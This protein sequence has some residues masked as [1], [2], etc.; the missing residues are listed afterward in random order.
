MSP[1]L[2]IA[3][4][5]SPD[6]RQK[7][8]IEVL[9]K[10]KSITHLATE[11]QVSRKF[12]HQQ[13]NKAKKA[14]TECFETTTPDHEV[15]FYLPITKSW[16]TQLMLGLILICHSSY[17]GVVELLR[18]LFD[19][20]ISVGTIHNRLESAAESAAKINE[21][22]DLSR[23]KV[24]LHDEI[25]QGSQPVLT[26]VDA[27]SLYCYLLA[28]VE[29]RDQETWSWHLL[30]PMEQ[31]F[32]PDFTVAD[33]AKGLRAG[34]KAVMPET[35]CHG[36]IFHML[37]QC[38]E[39]TNSLTR[40]VKGAISRILKL[41]E[42]TAKARLTSQ[43]TRKMTGKLVQ[44][45]RVERTLLPLEKDIKTLLQWLSQDVLELAGPSLALRQE[46]FDF[47]VLELEQRECKEHPKI[48]TLR[49]SLHNQRDELLAFAGI[50]DQKLAEIARCFK[51]PLQKVRDVYLLHRKQPTSNAYWERWNQLHRE[52]S[53]KLHLLMEAVGDA[54]NQTPR[55]SSLVENLNS[56]LRN[57]FFLRKQL[58]PSYL[59]LLQ[60]FLNHRCFM[61][62]EVPGRV[63]K[64]PTQL[65]TGESHRHWLEL[66]GFKRF[67]RA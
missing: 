63:D 57:Y 32:K 6:I 29:H 20:P 35:P 17:R 47:I 46:L 51:M 42:Q 45:K 60:F 4:S 65:M 9:S 39:L 43:V 53:G 3:A 2:S 5:L 28:G 36:D 56:R 16:L 12:L 24:G 26:G 67:Q 21:A 59:N 30:K 37:Q 31:G 66:L 38:Q 14:L 25:Y 19:L 10:S 22:Q 34:Q 8:A 61:R 48:G 18:D 44:A 62:S 11:H 1:S 27:A 33:G 40:Q 13:G 52:L 49:K 41:E 54:L 7:L 64:S 55:A 58:G 15:L 50:L 23:I